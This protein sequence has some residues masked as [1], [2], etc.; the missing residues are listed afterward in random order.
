MVDHRD[1][2]VGPDAA[3]AYGTLREQV[4]VLGNV[5]DSRVR[6]SR[7]ASSDAEPRDAPRDQVTGMSCEGEPRRDG[8]AA[9]SSLPTAASPARTPCEKPF[10][11]LPRGPRY[12]REKLDV[13]MR[14]KQVHLLLDVAV[15][16]SGDSIEAVGD[17]YSHANPASRC[18]T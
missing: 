13:V 9:A 8:T 11:T 2:R 6:S 12:A 1:Q 14:A 16:A 3:V 18:I 15:F 4:A 10:A 17:Q 7:S 5:S